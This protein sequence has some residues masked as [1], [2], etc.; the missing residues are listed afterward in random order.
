MAYFLHFEASL[1]LLSGSSLTV[2]HSGSYDLGAKLQVSAAAG[3]TIITGRV[4]LKNM[5]V[6]LPDGDLGVF[7]ELTGSGAG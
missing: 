2:K 7:Q 6:V 1:H 3:K 4:P 5:T